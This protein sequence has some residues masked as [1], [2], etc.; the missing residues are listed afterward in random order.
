MTRPKRY[1]EIAV[2]EST[3]QYC[4]HV[5]N[6]TIKNPMIIINEKEV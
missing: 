1:K 4:M 3:D 2:E 5:Q 6:I